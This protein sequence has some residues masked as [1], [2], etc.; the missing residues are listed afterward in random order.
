MVYSFPDSSIDNIIMYNN[1]IN[2]VVIGIIIVTMIICLIFI[3]RAE[4]QV[5]HQ[6]AEENDYTN[7]YN[8]NIEVTTC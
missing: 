2:G 1:I 6:W 5:G 3:R 8:N 7:K 4:V